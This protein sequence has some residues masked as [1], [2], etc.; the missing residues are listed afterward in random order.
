MT[1]LPSPSL[2]L[3]AFAAFT[4]NSE[5]SGSMVGYFDLLCLSGLVIS[6]LEDD[7]FSTS[8]GIGLSTTCLYVEDKVERPD[9]ESISVTTAD[10][11]ALVAQMPRVRNSSSQI[12]MAFDEAICFDPAALIQGLGGVVALLVEYAAL[13]AIPDEP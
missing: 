2:P 11:S 8:T 5:A 1:T 3:P 12:S 7:S 10:S 6:I 4:Q 13:C 9:S